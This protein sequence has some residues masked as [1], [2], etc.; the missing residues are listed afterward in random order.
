M[1]TVRRRVIRPSA[2]SGNS[3]CRRLPA[4]RTKLERE[5]E[6]LTRWMTRLKRAFHSFEKFQQRVTRLEKQI[7]TLEED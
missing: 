2:S 4:L 1:T 6:A 3:V 7:R 5:Q